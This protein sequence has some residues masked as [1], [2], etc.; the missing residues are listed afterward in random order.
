[1]RPLEKGE[2]WR[3]RCVSLADDLNAKRS[4]MCESTTIMLC[5]RP[6][7]DALYLRFNDRKTGEFIRTSA[8]IAYDYRSAAH[9][10]TGCLTSLYWVH[11]G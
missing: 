1:M 9:W 7:D 11:E 3:K 5:Q 4:K 2:T 10:L 6:E 8:V